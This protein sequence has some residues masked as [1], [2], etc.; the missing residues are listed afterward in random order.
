MF[1]ASLAASCAVMSFSCG[2]QCF[3]NLHY[4]TFYGGVPACQIEAIVHVSFILIEFF[5]VMFMSVS[6]SLQAQHAD[7]I[8][9][10][11]KFSR[12]R[13]W[14]V[15]VTIWIVCIIVTGLSTLFSPI[16]LPAPELYCFYK[17]SSFAIAGWLVPC[18]LLALITMFMCHV[19]VMRHFARLQNQLKSNIQT[20]KNLSV[21]VPSTSTLDT[22]IALVQ[23]KWRSTWFILTLLL[24]WISAAVA[25][26]Y[27]F[28]IGPINA[29][30][31]TAVGVGG[32]TFSW[33]VP[34]VFTLTSDDRKNAAI[35]LYGWSLVPIYGKAW[36]LA[37]WNPKTYT[38]DM[39]TK[40]FGKTHRAPSSRNTAPSSSSSSSSSQE[41][42][43]SSSGSE[44][45]DAGSSSDQNA[46]LEPNIT[47]EPIV[48]AEITTL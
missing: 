2:A 47:L 13:A 35:R 15:I 5:S 48:V 43:S 29:P 8:K 16:Y 34:L 26:V 40:R 36:F 9:Y 14:Q 7:G 33:A 12:K 18:L 31:T 24:G 32:V 27:E 41:A 22:N 10:S 23:F 28:S 46:T 20:N 44:T 11:R 19:R 17:F 21:R 4:G 30:M 25:V 6:F 1:A 3:V 39:S 42:M 45:D 38:P 37:A